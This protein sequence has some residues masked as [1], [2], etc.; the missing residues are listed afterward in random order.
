RELARL[1]ENGTLEAVRFSPERELSRLNEN[2]TLEA[3]RFS[4]EREMTRPSESVSESVNVKRNTLESSLYASWCRIAKRLSASSL[5][6]RLRDKERIEVLGWGYAERKIMRYGLWIII[7][8]NRLCGV[9]LPYVVLNHLCGVDLSYVVL[10]H[11]C[12]VDLPYV[13]LDHLCGVDLPYVVLDHLCAGKG[14][15]VII[16]TES[17]ICFKPFYNDHLQAERLDKFLRRKNTYISYTNMTWLAE[18]GFR[19]LHELEAQGD[20]HFLELNGCAYPS[21]IREFYGNFQQKNELFLVV[22][23]LASS[24]APLGDC[25]NDECSDFDSTEMYKSCL[26]D[27][28]YFVAG[29][30]TK[31]GSLLVEYRML[32]YLIAYIM[33][34]HNTNH[35]Q[36]TI[37][38]LKLMFAI[39]EGILVN[40]PSEILKVMVGIEKSSSRLLADGIFI[41]LVIDHL[42]IDT[43]DMEKLAV[44]P[45]EHLDGE[46]LICTTLN[47]HF[48]RCGHT[49]RFSLEREVAHLESGNWDILKDFR[50][51]EI[52]LAWVRERGL[53]TTGSSLER[54]RQI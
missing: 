28:S 37:N 40:W 11:L 29:E 30:L 15:L 8:L 17:I 22:G 48:L 12:G 9:D 7:V 4:P 6:V 21:L 2:G 43:S 14:T 42:D 34:H 23:G 25:N 46:N 19:F 32:H 10:D 44:N 13:V 35:A 24:D 50:L 3:V 49:P 31:V 16:K 26:R 54:E 5:S 38:Y 53:G 52:S 1:S 36:P 20:T 18:E 27:P 51:I 41:S 39:R 47:L 33:V 45:C